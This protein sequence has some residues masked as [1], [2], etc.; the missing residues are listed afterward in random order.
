MSRTCRRFKAGRLRRISPQIRITNP[1]LQARHL[2]EH[3]M[4]EDDNGSLVSNQLVGHDQ[5]IPGIIHRGQVAL[6]RL[7]T[8]QTWLDWCAVI[9]ALAEGRKSARP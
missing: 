7:E 3:Q 1:R 5:P 8:N 2:G 6:A 9:D 4:S